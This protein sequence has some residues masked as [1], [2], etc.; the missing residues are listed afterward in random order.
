MITAASAMVTTPA[1]M[2]ATTTPAAMAAA[3]AATSL[4]CGRRG[5]GAQANQGKDRHASRERPG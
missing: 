1:A 5:E 4:G 2:R 3:S